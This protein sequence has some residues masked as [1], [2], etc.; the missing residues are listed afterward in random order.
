VPGP[1]YFIFDILI[2][3]VAFDFLPVTD[4]VDFGYSPTEPYNEKFIWLG[5]ENSNFIHIMG[6]ITL[7]LIYFFAKGIF[8]IIFACVKCSR[9]LSRLESF[10]DSTKFK[11]G[12]IRFFLETLFELIICCLISFKMLETRSVWNKSDHVIFIISNCVLFLSTI[13]L[14]ISFFFLLCR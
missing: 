8:V 6:S 1:A 10:L 7:F 11:Q 9:R 14:F 12:L 5:Y 4:I 13:F 3:I 2:Q